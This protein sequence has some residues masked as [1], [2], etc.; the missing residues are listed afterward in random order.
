M[1]IPIPNLPDICDGCGNQLL[2]DE[3]RTEHYQKCQPGGLTH[4]R[5]DEVRDEVGHWC[6]IACGP[7]SVRT[8]PLIFSSRLRASPTRSPQP[9]TPRTGDNR[10]SN[11][12]NP[13]SPTTQETAQTE[14]NDNR[15]D[16][17][18]QSFYHR[19]RPTIIDVS[20]IASDSNSYLERNS[21]PATLLKTREKEK[22]NKYRRDCQLNRCDFTPFIMTSD[23]M[24]GKEAK[25]FVKTLAGKIANKWKAPYSHVCAL[26]KASIIMT[27]LRATSRCLHGSRVSFRRIRSA[28][29]YCKDGAGIGLFQAQEPFLE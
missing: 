11:D 14:G 24:L 15:G 27:C 22:K 29:D 2:T 16:L 6:S 5:H 9:N 28:E 10:P 17:A 20:I 8:E 19:G 1:G 23:G 25:D 21:A 7:S 4:I 26:I 18:V 3:A 12:N 13:S